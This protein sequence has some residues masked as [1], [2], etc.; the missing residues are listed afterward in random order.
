MLTG[1]PERVKGPR[2]KRPNP[3]ARMRARRS[4]RLAAS[5]PRRPRPSPIAR[6]R[7]R[8]EVKAAHAVYIRGP[9]EGPPEITGYPDVWAKVGRR[10]TGLFK[11]PE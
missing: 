6:F 2:M 9:L 5:L 3:L 11:F 7:A 4:V 8:R 10:L 1:K